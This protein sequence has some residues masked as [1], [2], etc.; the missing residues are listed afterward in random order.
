MLE[1]KNTVT[2]M[3]NVFDG[4]IRKLDMPKERIRELEDMSVRTPKA[5]MQREKKLKRQ[6]RLSKNCVTIAK[7]STYMKRKYQKEKKERK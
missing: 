1:I 5:V 4:L 6:S 3:K 2:K 7:G